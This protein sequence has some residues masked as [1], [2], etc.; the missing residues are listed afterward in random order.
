NLHSGNILID[1]NGDAYIGDTGLCKPIDPAKIR[2][3]S[4]PMRLTFRKR[5][6][7]SPTE[8]KSKPMNLFNDPLNRP[9]IEDI[10]K[11]LN[12]IFNETGFEIGIKGNGEI[13]RVLYQE[14]QRIMPHRKAKY[15]SKLIPF[16]NKKTDAHE[17][18]PVPLRN[19]AQN[20]LVTSNDLMNKLDSGIVEV[21]CDSG[22]IA[23]KRDSQVIPQVNPQVNPHT[24]PHNSPQRSSLVS[25]KQCSVVIVNSKENK[26]R[27]SR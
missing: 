20:N 17:I 7:S 15:V 1:E 11:I 26:P 10:E 21:K 2:R 22:I 25:N 23:A 8:S 12:M 16:L 14:R 13:R 27:A 18:K 3:S 19:G 6:N 4:E 24:S 9:S 5:T